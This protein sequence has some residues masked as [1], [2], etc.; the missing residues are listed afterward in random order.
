MKKREEKTQEEGALSGDEGRRGRV[1][2][3]EVRRGTDLVLLCRSQARGG[4]TEKL[5]LL[6]LALGV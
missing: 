1:G 4:K 6:G 3:G 5:G 2:G